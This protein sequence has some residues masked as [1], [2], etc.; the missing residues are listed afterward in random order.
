MK[1]IRGLWRSAQLAGGFLAAAALVWAGSESLASLARSYRESATA[2]KRGALRAQLTRFAAAHSKDSDGALAR[3]A[4]GISAYEQRDF[5][6][7]AADLEAARTRLPK[8]SDYL[9]YYLGAALHQGGH[10]AEAAETLAA[11]QSAPIASPL[12]GKALVLEARARTVLKTPQEAIRLLKQAYADLPQ[13]DADMALAMAYESAGDQPNAVIYYQR[14]YYRYPSS[15]MA[16]QAG[17]AL[18]NLRSALGQAYPPA[19]ARQMLDRADQLTAAHDYIR[20]RSEYEALL[21]QLGGL[22]RDQARVR[23]AET[24]FLRGSIQAACQSLRSLGLSKSEADAERL[25]YIAECGRRLGDDG[26]MM[27]AVKRLEHDYRES[28]WRLKALITAARKYLLIN[29]PDQYAPLYRAA[30]ESFPKDV[31]APSCHWKFTWSAYL[32]RASEAEELLKQHVERF[33]D[34]VTASASLYFLGRLAEARKDYEDARAYYDKLNARFPNYYYGVL[35]RERLAQPRVV[36][37][38]PSPKIT[39]FLAGI[40]FPT[41]RRVGSQGTPSAE[42]RLRIS[43]AQLLKSAGLAEMAE[44]ELRFG[45]RHDGQPQWLAIELARFGTAPHERLR[46]MKSAVPDYLSMP[47]S[48]APAGFW[49]LLFPLPYRADLMRNARLHNLDPFVVAGL[50][51]QESEFD[52]HALSHKRAYGLTQ[53]MPSTG[54]QIARRVG[55]RRLPNR[56]LFQ[57]STNLKLGTY[58]LRSLLD[59]WGGKWEETLASYNAGK[60]RVDDWLT[61]NHYREPAEFVESIPFTETRDYV[62]AVL[63]N[64][65]LYRE[66]YE[67]QAL[68]RV[69]DADDSPSAAPARKARARKV[70]SRSTAARKAKPGTRRKA[71]SANR[72]TGSGNS[73]T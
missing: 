32:E 18:M 38:K 41:N 1:T 53:V 31:T 70:S 20:A 10:Y 34:D 48:G 62:Q 7:A 26:E 15:D 16:G 58:Y 21:P 33:P 71:Q 24:D 4:L 19:T 49:E 47:L 51:R 66:L 35:A 64:A 45:V 52:P 2:S 56:A 13:P 54:R 55:V 68:V 3:L 57:P 25:Y 50:I 5:A 22:E 61:W 36:A 65:A 39:E 23:I 37:A 29:R 67:K 12:A 14:V 59:Q 43:R 11:I 44:S 17:A 6:S 28:P 73:R 40:P 42:T 46:Y 60:S 8:L 72:A 69:A 27:D 9:N 63:R 30:Y